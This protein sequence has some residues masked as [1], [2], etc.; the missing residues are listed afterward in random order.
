[1]GAKMAMKLAVAGAFHTEYMVRDVTLFLMCSVVFLY[2]W[3]LISHLL[4]NIIL[5]LHLVS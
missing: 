2:Q 5:K 1:M 3:L 4:Y